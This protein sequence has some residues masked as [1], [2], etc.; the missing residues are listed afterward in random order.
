MENR[1]KVSQMQSHADSHAL[2]Q[3]K[4]AT[5][6]DKESAYML[7]YVA[8]VLYRCPVLGCWAHVA[9]WTQQVM[10][11]VSAQEALHMASQLS[12]RHL[13]YHLECKE[14]NAAHRPLKPREESG[15]DDISLQTLRHTLRAPP[16]PWACTS[17][18][19]TGHV[20]S[21]CE[22]ANAYPSTLE[23]LHSIPD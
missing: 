14:V 1:Q 7:M 3:C 5:P 8:G 11:E 20:C 9:S 15:N 6:E 22:S 16:P 10:T 21:M 4:F 12:S 13:H 18:Q 19:W 2:I 23:K 17:F